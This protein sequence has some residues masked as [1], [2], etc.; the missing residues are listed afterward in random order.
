MSNYRKLRIGAGDRVNADIRL[1]ASWLARQRTTD[2]GGRAEVL[3]VAL[4]QAPTQ[5]FDSDRGTG[6]I[7]LLQN[8]SQ[9]GEEEEQINM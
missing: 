4:H 2:D 1:R 5:L 7:N 8:S 6:A 3:L 9:G